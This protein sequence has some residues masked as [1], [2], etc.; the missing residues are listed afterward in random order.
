MS[1]THQLCSHLTYIKVINMESDQATK[2]PLWSL[3]N[4]G[5]F[6]QRPPTGWQTTHGLM[7]LWLD[8]WAT[9]GNKSLGSAGVRF[10]MFLP[11]LRYFVFWHICKQTPAK[12]PL[13]ILDAICECELFLSPFKMSTLLTSNPEKFVIQICKISILISNPKKI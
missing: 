5:W 6:S 13:S 9:V 3:V 1:K 10:V 11:S 12:L 4:W 2:W 8:P 7:D